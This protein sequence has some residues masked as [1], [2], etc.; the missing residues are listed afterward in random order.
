MLLLTNKTHL[1]NLFG[2]EF[3][4]LQQWK[5][6]LNNIEKKPGPASSEGERPPTNPAIRVRF[7]TEADEFFFPVVAEKCVTPI[8]SNVLS[9]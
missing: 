4:N 6:T 9:S 5:C 7:S 2:I 3:R 1:T 8:Y